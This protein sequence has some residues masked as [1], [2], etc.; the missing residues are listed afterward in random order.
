[1]KGHEVSENKTNLAEVQNLP[2]AE[3]SELLGALTAAEL[4]ELRALEA[5]ESNRKGA[6]EAIDAALVAAEAPPAGVGDPFAEKPVEAAADE[7]PDWQTPDYTGPLDIEKAEWRR[8]NI[9]PVG[10]VSTK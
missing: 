2:I 10:E 9:K 5:S 6:L 7:T 1:V 4:H 8:H 3:M